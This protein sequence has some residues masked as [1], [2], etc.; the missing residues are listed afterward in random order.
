MKEND[1]GVFVL[2][3]ANGRNRVGGYRGILLSDKFI[4]NIYNLS[5][6]KE[7]AGKGG[8]CYTVCL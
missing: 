2:A 5:L 6:Q 4:T 8:G 7:E 1:W 3:L